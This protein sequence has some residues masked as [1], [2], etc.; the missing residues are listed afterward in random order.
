MQ[1][2]KKLER[3]WSRIFNS[4]LTIKVTAL[5]S[6]SHAFATFAHK[7]FLQVATWSIA[8]LWC[9]GP[10]F[11][12]Q[13]FSKQNLF[14]LFSWELDAHNWYLINRRGLWVL[15]GHKICGGY[16]VHTNVTTLYRTLYILL[17]G[18]GCAMHVPW[19]FWTMWWY[20]DHFFL[21]SVLARYIRGVVTRAH[22]RDDLYPICSKLNCQALLALL[23]SPDNFFLLGLL[24]ITH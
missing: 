15:I 3:W 8:W 11:E 1:S 19:H 10:R 23:C 7:N 9:W 2:D 17:Y 12:S 4:P 14:F 20:P 5:W 21:L 22:K 24:E 13:G 16:L 18:C 6:L